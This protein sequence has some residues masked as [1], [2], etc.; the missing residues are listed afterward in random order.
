M[1]LKV[2]ACEVAF[3]E[4]CACAARSPNQFDLDFLSQ[5]YH[6]NPE[7]GIHRIQ[8]CIDAVPEGHCE[9]HPE[10]RCYWNEVVETALR[11]DRFDELYSVQFPKDPSLLHTSS[12]RNE[13]MGL[14]PPPLDLEGPG[15]GPFPRENEL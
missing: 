4:L 7:V 8:E 14:I 3:R 13:V 11:A 2:I 6:D 9:V 5:G 12:W 1:F 10:R 15:P